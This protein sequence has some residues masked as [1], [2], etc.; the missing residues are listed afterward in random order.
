MNL[1]S[2]EVRNLKLACQTKLT[3]EQ[4][5]DKKGF[6][7]DLDEGKFSFPL[8]HCI[9]SLSMPPVSNDRAGLKLLL[10]NMLIS[11]CSNSDHRQ[12]P[13]MK[14]G[15]LEILDSTGSLQETRKLLECLDCDIK[16][17]IADIERLSGV[18][19]LGL[20]ALASKLRL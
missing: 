10:K 12:T 16:R 18:E 7:E 8:V 2:Q 14:L 11:R 4:Y 13:E 3:P 6:C 9:N 1:V 15:I 17:Q 5:T 20:R 19:N